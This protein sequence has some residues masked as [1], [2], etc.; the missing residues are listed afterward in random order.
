MKF[1]EKL[2]KLRKRKA[3]SQEEFA[4][5]IG[6]T[7]QTVSKWELGQTTPDAEKLSKIA[8]LFGISPNDLLDD[9]VNLGQNNSGSLSRKNN[10]KILKLFILI[11]ILIFVLS[12]IGLI[13]LNKIFNK[14]T[15]PEMPKSIAQMFQGNTI[16]D[17]FNIIS[18]EI[19]KQEKDN[20][21][22]KFKTFYY[23]DIGGSSV[24][25]F[26]DEIIK[27]N[28]ENSDKI[29][30]LKYK[31]IETANSQ[32]IRGIKN[33]ININKNYEISY[34][35]DENGYIKKAIILNEKL[36]NFAIM[37]FNTQFKTMYFGT[38][39]GFFMNNFIDSVIKSNE[40]NP[41]N[42]ITVSYNGTVTNNSDELRNMKKE[43]NN[44]TTYDI[45][46]EYDEDGLITKA[47][48]QR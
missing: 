27:S 43:F 30:T 25:N 18:A 12:G 1:E 37:S 13:T 44:N 16:S 40:E 35:Y 23:G 19:N 28:E 41:D 32:E 3:W 17:I 24:N 7:R 14:V 31:D 26:L 34:E 5:K 9:T 29:I 6:V 33:S 42:L 46:Y 45:S 47:N 48:I 4:E 2:M 38:T 10:N 39:T 22:S 11:L 21:N 36:S 15:N 8:A 20:F